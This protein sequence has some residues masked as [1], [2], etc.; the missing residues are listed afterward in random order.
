MNACSCF[1]Y[2]FIIGGIS[3]KKKFSYSSDIDIK[4]IRRK[5]L[6]NW[7]FSNVFLLREKIYCFLNIIPLDAY[8]FDNIASLEN[9]MSSIEEPMLFYTNPVIS[10]NSKKFPKK[11][12]TNHE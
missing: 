11:Y 2:V 5:G 10:A 9:K 7:F 8:V 1:L 6:L 4:F 3:R 12:R